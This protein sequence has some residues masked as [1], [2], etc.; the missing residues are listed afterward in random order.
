M[1]VKIEHTAIIVK[2]LEKSINYYSEMFGYK[3]R[4][5]GNNGKRHMAFIFLENQPGIEIEL[6]QDIEPVVNN[7]HT[8]V[9]NHLAFTVEN[10]EEAIRFYQ[11]KGIE[12][13]TEQPNPTLDGGKNIFFDGPDGELLQLVQP[14]YYNN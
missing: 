8:G 1:I 3:L 4:T 13:K 5:K 9:V 7:S 11:Q 6:I 2:D 12:F 10:M 14:A